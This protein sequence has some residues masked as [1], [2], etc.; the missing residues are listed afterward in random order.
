[1]SEILAAGGREYLI[2]AV[3]FLVI[4]YAARGLFGLHGRRSQQRKEFLELWMTS[5]IQDDLWLE[6]A[7]RHLFGTFL[8]APIIRLALRQAD[9]GQA[10]LE[11]CELW[12]LLHFDRDS[13]QVRWLHDRHRALKQRKLARAWFS[14]AYFL[15]ASLAV[16]AAKTAL[17]YG[18]TVFAGWLYGVGAVVSG[19][20]AFVCLAREDTMKTAVRVGSQWVGRINGM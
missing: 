14:V 19:L 8:P 13:K 9:Q 7:I 12:P 11:L 20:V 4:L 16:F 15:C 17:T 2:P 10:L 6:V 18:P 5:R 3:L 1:M